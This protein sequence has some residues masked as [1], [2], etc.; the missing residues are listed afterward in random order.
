MTEHFFSI[1]TEHGNTIMAER[2]NGS[3]RIV[4]CS[5]SLSMADAQLLAAAMNRKPGNTIEVI[6]RKEEPSVSMVLPMAVLHRIA[7]ISGHLSML[8]ADPR[9]SPADAQRVTTLHSHYTLVT[10]DIALR[11][12]TAA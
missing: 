7:T 1:S 12:N 2:E 9:L 10:N 3:R 11:H 6:T 8:K 5:H 4:V